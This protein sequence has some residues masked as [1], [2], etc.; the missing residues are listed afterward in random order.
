[1]TAPRPAVSDH[2][3]WFNYVVTRPSPRMRM[4]C[5]S[6]A[7]TGPSEFIPWS[8][9]L[10]DDV[11]IWPVQLPGRERRLREAPWSDLDDI[12]SALT[13]AL[14]ATEKGVPLPLVLFGHS[15]GALVMYDLCRRILRGG[16][17]EVAALV[18]SGLAAPDRPRRRS[19]VAD[20]DDAGLLDWIRKL[21]GTPE[22]LL[23]SRGFTQWLLQD[24]RAGYRIRHAYEASTEPLPHP[25]IVF[26]G[27]D[28]FEA[29]E[30]DLDA[31]SRFTSSRFR[32]HTL[33]GGHFYLREQRAQFLSELAG[34]LRATGTG[35]DS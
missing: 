15:F 35:G 23:R 6:G 10:P 5:L 14:L 29:G 33:P 32:R 17:M 18:V 21:D 7:G 2:G 13:S 28:D 8:G 26:G 31:W 4:I 9:G 1:M 34:E 12:V 30:E 24:L 20:L 11:E 3:P 16:G 22:E 19:A 25:L 27:S